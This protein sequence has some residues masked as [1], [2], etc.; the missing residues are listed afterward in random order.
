[1]FNLK[2]DVSEL[3][4]VNNGISRSSYQQITPTRDCSSTNFHGG[5]ISYRFETAGNSWI[6]PN[7][8]Y[9]R[10]RCN[11]QLKVSARV[12]HWSVFGRASPRT[13]RILSVA[14]HHGQVTVYFKLKTS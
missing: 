8:S 3:S 13:F 10:M 5:Q 7:K 11:A 1:M 2:Q 12:R 14:L 4:S 6:V 9:I